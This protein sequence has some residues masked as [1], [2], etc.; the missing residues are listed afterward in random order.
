MLLWPT[1]QIIREV[2][3]LYAYII[4]FLQR[5]ISWYFEG[6]L[7]HMFTAVFRPMPLRFQD[8][9]E[10]ISSCS[11]TIDRLAETESQTTQKEMHF[12]LLEIKRAMTGKP[13]RNIV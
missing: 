13:Y 5:A 3:H 6:R 1:P 12:L 8:L 7:K 4:K 10:E 2:S 11:Q 9:L